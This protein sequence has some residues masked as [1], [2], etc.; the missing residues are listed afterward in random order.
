MSDSPI[1]KVPEPPFPCNP[2]DGSCGTPTL[3]APPPT[4]G[5]EPFANAVQ[6]LDWFEKLED[7]D[8]HAI[9]D[10]RAFYHE[11]LTAWKAAKKD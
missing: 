2:Q 6:V 5:A 7:T 4:P 8:K 9:A 11:K 3:V 1:E 10:F